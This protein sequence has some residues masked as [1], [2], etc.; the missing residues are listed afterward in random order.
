MRKY[1]YD[2]C[3]CCKS[4]CARKLKHRAKASRPT[5]D[6][7]KTLAIIESEYEHRDNFALKELYTVFYA[8]VVCD[9]IPFIYIANGL[10]KYSYLNI[11]FPIIGLL[12]TVY[13]ILLSMAYATRLDVT[14]QTIRKLN[15][16]LPENLRR[17]S[18]QNNKETNHWYERRMI[19]SWSPKCM[20]FILILLDVSVF[21]IVLAERNN[22]FMP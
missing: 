2:C 14:C 22:W 12:F 5:D 18:I 17:I 1:R 7:L 13:F 6:V 10:E 20:A 16:Q 19:A 11:V 15:E 4:R 21:V 9:V 8:T 3:R